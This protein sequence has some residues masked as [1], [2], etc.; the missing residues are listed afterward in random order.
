[1]NLVINHEG[2]LTIIGN[3]WSHLKNVSYVFIQFPAILFLLLMISSVVCTFIVSSVFP[4]DCIGLPI[5][6][7]KRF[8]VLPTYGLHELTGWVSSATQSLVDIQAHPVGS[9]L[10]KGPKHAMPRALLK[11]T[12][13][14]DSP[15]SSTD[16]IKLELLPV[17]GPSSVTKYT[18]KLTEGFEILVAT[19]TFMCMPLI[20][21]IALVGVT[22]NKYMY[23]L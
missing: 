11:Y 4:G 12:K 7:T 15:E 3:S 17:M 8:P 9:L 10:V 6:S 13:A 23:I 20:V 18:V 2:K 21:L 19:C 16:R 1:M 5:G 22:R 14:H